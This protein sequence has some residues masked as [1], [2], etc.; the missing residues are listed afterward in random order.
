MYAARAWVTFDSGNNILGSGNVTSVT[1]TSPA[2]TITFIA[3]MPNSNYAVSVTGSDTS[4][5]QI[6]SVVSRSTN[7]CVVR[8][9][10]GGGGNANPGIG[11]VIVFG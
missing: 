11:N 8:F 4:N 10:G 2:I 1:G 5:A 3:P 7:S 6:G 9:L